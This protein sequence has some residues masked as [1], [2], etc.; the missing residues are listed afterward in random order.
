MTEKYFCDGCGKELGYKNYEAKIHR[1][2]ER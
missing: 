1:L 2:G